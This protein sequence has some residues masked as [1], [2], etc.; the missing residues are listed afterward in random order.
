M[1]EANWAKTQPSAL[2]PPFLSPRAQPSTGPARISLLSLTDAAVPPVS[3]DAPRQRRLPSPKSRAQQWQG[4]AGDPLFISGLYGQDRRG[5]ARLQVPLSALSLPPP[6][7]LA[8]RRQA[9]GSHRLTAATPAGKS[10][11]PSCTPATPAPLL[12][13]F[14]LISCVRSVLTPL[15]VFPAIRST[16]PSATKPSRRCIQLR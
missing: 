13:P 8:K 9:A 7:N 5:R 1:E 14:L 3:I 15:G 12:H 16:P 2:L 6:K 4:T 11:M 10:S